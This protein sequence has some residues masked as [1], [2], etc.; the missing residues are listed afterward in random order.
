MSARDFLREL[1][2]DSPHIVSDIQVTQLACSGAFTRPAHSGDLE[3]AAEIVRDMAIPGLVEMFDE[4][5][6]AAEYFLRPAF[7]ALNLEYVP[8]NVFRPSSPNLTSS[9]LHR[10]ERLVRLWGGDLYEDLVRLNQLDLELFQRAE[11][12]IQRR[13]ALVPKYDRRL[14]E[15]R[16]R[17]ARLNKAA[18][19]EEANE[20]RP[21]QEYLAPVL[22][23]EL[24]ETPARRAHRRA[25]H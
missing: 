10:P 15:F 8:H 2:N 11:D 23:D 9:P 14:A 3:R 13:I 5:L 16:A 25:P 4:S 22:V 24:F 20:P 7:P 21:E 19:A 6:V 12:E 17:C 18:Y 1:V